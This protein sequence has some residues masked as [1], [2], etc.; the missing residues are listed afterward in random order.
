MS[1]D[2]RVDE[3]LALYP[4][5]WSE[6]ATDAEKTLVTSNLRGF[7]ARVLE[8]GLGRGEESK[9]APVE[10][11]SSL[12]DFYVGQMFE[13]QTKIILGKVLTVIDAIGIPDDRQNKAIKDVVKQ[14]FR[15]HTTNVRDLCGRNMAYFLLSTPPQE[16]T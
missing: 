2:N 12:S 3:L 8:E 4:L 7:A 14:T 13:L 11:L 16:T 1:V 15:A 9:P 10:D 5:T 6:D